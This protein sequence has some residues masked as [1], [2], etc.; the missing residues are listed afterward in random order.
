MVRR[1]GWVVRTAARQA[2]T[3]TG[4][5]RS[6]GGHVRSAAGQAISVRFV[7]RDEEEMAVESEERGVTVEMGKEEKEKKKF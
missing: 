6:A 3:A 7:G 4:H 5:V 2:R 1:K